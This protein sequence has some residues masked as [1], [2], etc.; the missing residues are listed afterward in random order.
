MELD[1]SRR[2]L[3]VGLLSNRVNPSEIHRKPTKCFKTI[4]LEETLQVEGTE[5]VQNER[6]LDTPNF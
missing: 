3:K 1:L 6:P 2:D 5:M 4:V